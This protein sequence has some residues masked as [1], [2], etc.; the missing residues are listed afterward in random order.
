MMN[1]LRTAYVNPQAAMHQN[2]QMNP[3][4]VNM[5]EDSE[6]KQR[7]LVEERKSIQNSLLLL[8]TTSGD[9]VGSEE[10]VELL[11]KKLEELESRIKAG[12]KETAEIP[13]EDGKTVQ[14]SQKITIRNNFDRYCKGKDR[15]YGHI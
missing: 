11:E 1:V 13:A 15:T 3:V 4:N 7:A 2:S 6:K 9:S 5:A 10:S 14:E 8:K 12:E